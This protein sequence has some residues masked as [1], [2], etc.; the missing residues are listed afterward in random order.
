ME[1]KGA[2]GV[3]NKGAGGVKKCA[4]WSKLNPSGTFS[5]AIKCMEDK[6]AGGVKNK[7]E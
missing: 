5:P 7:G 6:G 1:D 4:F 2:G 3:K